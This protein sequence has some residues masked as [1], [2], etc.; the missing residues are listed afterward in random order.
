[1]PNLLAR[2]YVK[3]NGSNIDSTALTAGTTYNSEPIRPHFS[4]G[5]A[6]L[7]LLTTGSITVTY[8]VSSNGADWYN[9]YD[10]DGTTVNGIA[11]DLEDNRWI[12][13]EPVP[14]EWM[15]IVIVCNTTST[16][17]AIYHHQEER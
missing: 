2:Q 13:F 17:S 3:Y 7:L 8:Q 16:V 11:Q 12:A 10:V 1:M 14:C 4:R 15:R 6:A 5:K 9:P